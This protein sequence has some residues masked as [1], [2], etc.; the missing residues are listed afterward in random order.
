MSVQVVLRLRRNSHG[1]GRRAP[2]RDAEQHIDGHLGVDRL[3]QW[4]SRGLVGQPG[5]QAGEVS[6]RHQVGLVQDDEVGLGELAQHRVA[7]VLVA[8]L[9]PDQFRID[10]QNDAV[11]GKLVHLAVLGDLPRIGHTAGFDDNV[12]EVAGPVADPADRG[13]ETV[14]EAAAGTAVGEVDGIPVMA[15]DEFDVNVDTAEVVDQHCDPQAAGVGQQVVQECGLARAEVTA[16]DGERQL[17]LARWPFWL[18]P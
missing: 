13:G 12:I 18:S 17:I 7:H 16:D 6:G 8:R 5:P 15:A 4:C 1:H 9:G 11:E 10:H 3:D 2:A 14:N